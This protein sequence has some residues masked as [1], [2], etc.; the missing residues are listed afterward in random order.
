MNPYDKFKPGYTLE[1]RF[2]IGKLLGKGNMGVVY[3]GKDERLDRTVAIKVVHLVSTDAEDKESMSRRVLRE[4]QTPARMTHPNIVT[5]Y[6]YG[7]DGEDYAYIVMEF[8]QGQTL[9]E[10]YQ[11]KGAI[12]Y[13]EMVP[14]NDA[15]C[16]AL[17]MAHD[18]GVIHRDIKPANIMMLPNGLIKVMDF[19]LAKFVLGAEKDLTSTGLL[20]GTPKYMAPEQ[21]KGQK[22]DHR[23]DI[24]ATGVMN[25]ELLTGEAPFDGDSIYTILTAIL[26]KNPPRAS[27]MNHELPKGLDFV[28]E[29]AMAKDPDKRYQSIEEFARDFRDVYKLSS[30][31][32]KRRQERKRESGSFELRTVMI[33][34]DDLPIPQQEQAERTQ[35]VD[36]EL[37]KP[38]KRITCEYQFVGEEA[39]HPTCQEPKDDNSKQKLCFWHDPDISK[40]VDKV[41]PKLIKMVKSGEYLEGIVLK[42]LDLNQINL[43][44]AKFERVR[45]NNINF[46]GS[47]LR[48]ASLSI[49][50][51]I[52]V[53]FIQCDLIRSDLIATRLLECGFFEAILSYCDFS[54]ALAR[55]CDFKRAQMTNT[56]SRGGDFRECDFKNSLI[57]NAD[58]IDSKFIGCDIRRATVKNTKF[59]KATFRKCHLGFSAFTECS[60]HQTIFERA[61]L[62]RV[63]LS[64]SRLRE[65]IIDSC[66]LENA[67]LTG[68]DLWGAQIKQSNLSGVNLK[69]ADMSRCQLSGI[70][71]NMAVARNCSF[72][73]SNLFG[74]S[75]HGADLKGADFL[76]ADLQNVNLN[77]A[78]IKGA[79]FTGAKLN[80]ERLSEQKLVNW[81]EATWD[82]DVKRRLSAMYW[83]I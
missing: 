24:Y 23:V 11:Q 45:F 25:Y 57:N 50:D 27:N 78:D 41:K 5:I 65:C 4:A 82:L 60:F 48:E 83:S 20:V 72:R 61:L 31:I 58:F 79:D 71:F 77:N 81:E 26:Q 39:I 54:E 21:V 76:E 10:I 36:I 34:K 22:V 68:C 15:V 49:A 70:I 80:L 19:G 74:A 9:L 2:V 44:R 42:D 38:V 51:L 17:Q 62:G 1:K 28:L 66:N 13:K 59:D 73:G 67:D 53:L 40:S 16:S 7:L 14:I 35:I 29:K 55:K 63:D 3:L 47:S 64:N 43:D 12:P 18:Q 6:D 30:A 33:A 37:D 75:F 52:R 32:M 8:V 46:K 56:T 69:D